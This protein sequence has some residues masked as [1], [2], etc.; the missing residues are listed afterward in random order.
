MNKA[1][2]IGIAAV[3]GLTACDSDS[4]GGGGDDGTSSGTSSGTTPTAGETLTTTNPS[5][6]TESGTS[7]TTSAE[8]SSTGV[9][10]STTSPS[11]TSETDSGS[12]SSSTGGEPGITPCQPEMSGID[13]ERWRAEMGHRMPT[14]AELVLP[15]GDMT[16]SASAAGSLADVPDP[17]AGGDFITVPDGGGVSVECDVWAQ[18]CED[19]EKCAAW[20]NDGGSAWNAT[21]C[22]P[23][24]QDPV[25][26]GE[27]CAVEGS[28][29]SGIDNC[30]Q[31]AMCWDVDA[32]TNEGTCVALCD[33]TPDAPTCAPAGTACSISNEGVLILCLPICN[34]LADEC[35]DGQ[36]C[37]PIGGEYFQ[38]GPEA[39]GDDAGPGT[40]CEFL[41]ACEDGTACVSPQTVPT[42][43]AGSAG[44][45]SSYCDPAA[46]ESG[47]L[48]GQDC[49]P[50]YEMGE[51][52]DVCLEGV[53]ICST[54]A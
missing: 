26:V 53:G 43:P 29:V 22:V 45:C 25:D 35:A 1:L 32:E 13:L 9:G 15:L 34:P 8:G 3:F 7:S 18:D 51:E 10:S 41:N 17:Q 23:V 40:P 12:S 33:G 20:A 4:T 36:G 21:R 11:T 31:G 2:L 28:G 24:A 14:L 30:D 44:C 49:L 48:D 46:E 52:P 38:C 42:C 50:W 37:Y 16:A 54:P 27:T 39:G 19:G 6:T 47:C 5:A